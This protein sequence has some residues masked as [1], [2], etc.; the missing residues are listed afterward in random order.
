MNETTNFSK[1]FFADFIAAR[2]MARRIEQDAARQIHGG[3]GAATSPATE[4]PSARGPNRSDPRS[5]KLSPTDP[6]PRLL[7]GLGSSN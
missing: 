1:R 2:L 7:P 4:D 5:A 6:A 3:A